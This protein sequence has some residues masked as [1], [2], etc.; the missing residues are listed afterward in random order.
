M[1]KQLQKWADHIDA[2]SLRERAYVFFAA[3]LLLIFVFHMGFSKPVL[4]RQK[5]VQR[6]LAQKQ[7]DIRQAQDQIQHMVRPASATPE[8]ELKN[9]IESLRQQ[10]AE[11]DGRLSQKQ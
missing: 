5:Q 1:K 2:M 3:A 9:R 10:V 4:D 6:D 7:L 11:I 8:G